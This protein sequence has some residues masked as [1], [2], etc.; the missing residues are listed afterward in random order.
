MSYDDLTRHPLSHYLAKV[1]SKTRLRL[2]ESL[3]TGYIQQFPVILFEGQILDGWNRHEICMTLRQNGVDITPVYQDFDGDI[4]A[5][6]S[7][8][9][10]SNLARRHLSGTAIAAAYALSEQMLPEEMRHTK[11]EI[12]KISGLGVATV[13]KVIND[14]EAAPDVAEKFVQGK[15]TAADLGAAGRASR[16]NMPRRGGIVKHEFNGKRSALLRGTT[17]GRPSKSGRAPQVGTIVDEIIDGYYNK[18]GHGD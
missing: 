6:T 16:G 13:S 10:Q 2:T 4:A 15:A 17:V 18:N 14:A 9:Q 3:K 5:A 12:A 1:D 8:A 11:D 7:Y